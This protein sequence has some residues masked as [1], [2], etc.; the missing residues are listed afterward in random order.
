MTCNLVTLKL[1]W[2][3][4]QFCWNIIYNSFGRKQWYRILFFFF[5]IRF[6]FYLHC[7]FAL[8]KRSFKWDFLFFALTETWLLENIFYVS[9][10]A[11]LKAKEYLQMICIWIEIIKV[12]KEW[13][14]FSIK[15]LNLML[16]DRLNNLVFPL[17]C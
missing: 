13:K 12:N 8:Q 16:I 3:G 11:L 1:I 7:L 17:I 4:I 6:R 15:E 9:Q 14:Y 2:K 10:L 5:G